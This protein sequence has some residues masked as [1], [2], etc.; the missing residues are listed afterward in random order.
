MERPTALWLALT[1]GFAGF[2]LALVGGCSDNQLT[3]DSADLT[4]RS[5]LSIV[6]DFSLPDREPTDHPQLPQVQNFGGP[7]LANI[8]IWTVVWQGDEE[9]GAQVHK[10]QQ[11][12]LK[13]TYWVDSLDEY[14]VGPGTSKGVV[15]WP[16]PAPANLG[17]NELKNIVKA[18]V[19]QL[20]EPVNANSV[21]SFIIPKSTTL[22][23]GGEPGCIS[24]G[25][26]H[27]Q[28]RT[29]AGGNTFI[30]Y[31]VNLQ[32]DE[33]EKTNFD[34]L[35][36]VI[37]H[38]AAEAAT[39]PYPGVD[40]AWTNDTV[41]VGGEVG[42]ICVFL[43]TKFEA[44]FSDVDAGASHESYV[45]QRLYSQEIA[46]SGN[47]DPCQPAPMTPYFNVALE[48]TDS[49][50]RVDATTGVGETIVQIQ[51]FAYGDVGDIDFIIFGAGQVPGI[52][53]EPNMGKTQ[54]G[55]TIGLVIKADSMAKGQTAPLIVEAK[56][57]DG[58]TNLWYG[59]VTVR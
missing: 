12:M 25:G 22:T 33:P 3:N 56:T 34:L 47:A 31:M 42:D 58:A 52:T 50:V 44:D 1:L 20:P 14:G 40:P 21:V 53:I 35:T 9:L 43:T 11:W 15:V 45:V 38:E 59:S 24:Y 19:A 48:P 29:V 32:C 8:E 16:S 18:V 57:S 51:P 6:E 26:Y 4:A 55:K 23:M 17:D 54:A 39:D 13:S 7:V 27:Y 36:E 30:P 10:F 5:D 46:A 49:V 2:A 37:S 28:T 41:I